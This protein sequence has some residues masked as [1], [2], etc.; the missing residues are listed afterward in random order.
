MPVLESLRALLR[1]NATP[2]GLALSLTAG[3]VVGMTPIPCVTTAICGAVI[4]L[5]RLNAPAVLLV[6]YL[7]SVPQLA[8]IV[9][10]AILG[11]WLTDTKLPSFSL[12]A[13]N[14]ISHSK[15]M[16]AAVVHFA[17]P[18]QL[19]LVGWLL[20][21]LLLAPLLYG[22][23]LLLVRSLAPKGFV[24]MPWTEEEREEEV[25]CLPTAGATS[26]YGSAA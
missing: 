14:A 8:M 10:Y 26:S 15:G 25:P 7:L 11:S 16:L 9:P 3:A 2:A 22:A 21:S 19:A 13:L 4:F 23:F 24:Q 17:S 5:A 18:L 20:S 12:A 6:N 1:Q